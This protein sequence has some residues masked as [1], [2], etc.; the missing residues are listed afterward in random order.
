[1]RQ[2]CSRVG[3]AQSAQQVDGHDVARAFPDRIERHFAVDTRHDAFP[4]GLDITIA[5]KALHRFLGKVAAAFANPE[6]GQWRQ[7]PRHDPLMRIVGVV[8]GPCQAQRQH[9]CRFALQ[10]KVGQHVAHQGLLHQ[11]LSERLPL[12]GVVQCNT[13]GL[14]H[15]AT[16]AQG[17]IQP[18]H[19]AHFENLG[20]AASFLAH[21]PGAC[22]HKLYFGTGVGLVTQLVLEALELN[23][24][25]LTVGQHTRQKQA[26]QPTRSLGQDQK[27]VAHRGRKKPFVASHRI[28]RAPGIAV[29]GHGVGGVG[30][31]VRATLLFGHAHAHRDTRLVAP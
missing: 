19:A 12:C 26:R 14:A 21:Q 9:T 23:G 1:M 13:Q 2:R 20:D 5:T 4:A 16:G 22:L 6:L 3:L 28:T 7:N 30:P 15:Q 24:I 31:H 17:T 18:G 8:K 25:G 27:R 29:I 10:R 11:G